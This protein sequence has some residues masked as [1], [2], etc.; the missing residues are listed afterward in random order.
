MGPR[1][2]ERGDASLPVARARKF[3]F[4]Q[5]GR[6]QM[7]AEIWARRWPSSDSATLQWGR[8]QMSA[9][10]NPASAA[11][12]STMPLQWGRAQM[13]AE[14]NPASAAATSTMPLQWGR[15]QMSAE[16]AAELLRGVADGTFNGAALR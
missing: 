7:S 15:A 13:S 10:I 6:A 16:M 3:N 4:L 12:T 8:A 14:I 9:E 11:A 2:D 5:W 1:S